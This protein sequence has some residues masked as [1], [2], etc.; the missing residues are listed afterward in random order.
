MKR[1]R[2]GARAPAAS[3]PLL[4]VG[5]YRVLPV[6]VRGAGGDGCAF[7]RFVYFRQHWN[8]GEA[9]DEPSRTIFATNLP[10]GTTEADVEQ[11]FGTCGDVE[12]VVFGTHRAAAGGAAA[13][14]HFAHISFGDAR[15]VARALAMPEA[16]PPDGGGAAPG[17]G[18]LLAPGSGPHGLAK[19]LDEY[20][21]ARPD[22]AVLQQEVDSFM[23]AFEAK[24]EEAAR[25]RAAAEAAA[26]A[27]G[28]TMVSS[29]KRAR[30]AP[31][32]PSGKGSN[33]KKKAPKELTNFYR[34][35]VRE[36]KRDALATLRARFEEDK[37]E[38]ERRKQARVFK[39][40]VA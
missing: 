1:S 32:K 2:S 3:V 6:P 18:G 25:R 16:P 17:G 10:E 20:H 19:Y 7:Q 11:L 26:D 37:L 31:G 8:K 36:S 23:A 38:L 22:E 21:A 30:V 40:T 28:F 27:D 29:K 15:S 14:T 24:E 13:A 35:Q 33:K 34:F 9:R 39:E 5:G 4:A 12:S